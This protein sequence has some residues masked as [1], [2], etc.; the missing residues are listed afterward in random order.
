MVNSGE[1]D[2]LDFWVFGL[3]PRGF[4]FFLEALFFRE[5]LQMMVV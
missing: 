4:V 3:N 2:E 1:G 5:R